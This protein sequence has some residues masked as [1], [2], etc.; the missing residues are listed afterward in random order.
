MSLES[1]S[2]FFPFAPKLAAAL[3]SFTRSPPSL[4]G[5]NLITYYAG[6]IYEQFLGFNAFQSRLLAA[7]NGLEYFMASWIAVYTIEKFGRRKLMLFGAIGMVSLEMQGDLSRGGG[8]SKRTPKTDLLLPFLLPPQS[9]SMAI[10]AAMNSPAALNFD[11]DGKAQNSA[12]AVVAAVFLFVF[13]SFFAV[14]WLG[15]TWLYPAEIT[16]LSI[17]AAANGI[18]TSSNWLFNF[19]VVLITPIGKFIAIQN[20][21]LLFGRMRIHNVDLLFF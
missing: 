5:I 11:A 20:C 18:S 13:N 2:R 14:G 12:P 4:S 3:L 1:L 17:R 19:M 9:G 8:I 7:F 21:D 16:P 15:M 6:T 10:L